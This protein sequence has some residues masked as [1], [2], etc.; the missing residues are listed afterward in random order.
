MGRSTAQRREATVR[1]VLIDA[2]T[3][4]DKYG[5]ELADVLD[6]LE[7]RRILTV[8][9]AVDPASFA[10]AESIAARTDL[11]VAS[12]GVHPWEAPAW[13][14]RLDEVQGLIERS[15]MVGEVG[16]DHRFVKDADQYDAQQ[17]VFRHFL[18]RA[19]EQEKVVNLHCSGAE[20]ETLAMLREHGNERVIVHWYSGPLD[21]LS[22][23]IA[24]GFLFTVGVEVLVSDHIRQVAR[25]IPDDKLLTETDNPGGH[26]WLTGEVG[27]P[28]HLGRVVEE[29]GRVR[30]RTGEEIEAMVEDNLTRLVSDD[31]HLSDWAGPLRR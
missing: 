15:P 2:H 6:S 11:V 12:F 9:V 22:E 8:S 5:A 19:V 21:V 30:G 27:M 31:P 18:V 26:R 10:V 16:L 20:A 28:E 25:I 17:E 29:V 24:V 3:H 13:V 23:M 7:D 4:L 1:D 14:G